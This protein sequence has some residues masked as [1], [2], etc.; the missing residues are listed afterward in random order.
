MRDNW[1]FEPSKGDLGEGVLKNA[2]HFT[3]I[4][5]VSFDFLNSGDIIH[6]SDL[7]SRG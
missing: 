6:M 7:F 3:G 4:C 2:P 1:R 5:L